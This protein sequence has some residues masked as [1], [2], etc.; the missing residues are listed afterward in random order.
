M[1]DL[2]HEETDNLL[3]RMEKEI[4]DVY[5]NAY[6]DAR[7]TADEYMLR[8]QADDLKK[9]EQLHNGKITLRD[10]KAWRKSH[11]LTGQ[12]YQDMA[13]ALAKD[14]TNAN[15]IAASIINGYLP[16]VYAI[17]GNYAAYQVES[18]SQ[19]NTGFT[20]YS[21][22]TV[23]RLILDKPDL[24]PMMVSIDIPIDLR[25]NKQKINS[26]IMQG[27]LTSESIQKIAKRL[28]NVTNMNHVSAVR[29]ARTMVTS[30]ENGGRVDSYRRAEKM[31]IKLKQEW[32]ATL[33]GRTR[34]SH[35]QLDGEKVKV[36]DKFSNGCRFPADPQ[37]A[38]HEVYNCRCTLVASL[39]GIDDSDAERYSKLGDMTYDE[40]KRSKPKYPKKQVKNK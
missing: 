14:M 23:E 8:F 3:A 13:D 15:Q 32:V 34:H 39:D 25:W 29:N 30:A 11:L 35:R 19:I 20:L 6:K 18:I 38:A 10:Y 12:R 33:D 26:A 7:K 4:R 21:R 40:W 24:L 27:I 17:N 37:G 2:G 36:G 31:G 22:E 9:R 28:A 1:K 5:K 16:E